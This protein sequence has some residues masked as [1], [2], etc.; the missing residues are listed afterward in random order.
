MEINK[1][2]TPYNYSNGELSRIKYIVI[3]YV[4][5]LGGAE[6]NCKYYA[7]QYVGAS[8]HYFV[9]FSGEIWQSVEDKNIAWH[10]GAKSYIHPECRNSNS[11]GIE[12]C[13]RNKGSQ[14]DT[15]RDWYFEDATV[16]SAIKLTKH[17]MEQY[18][19]REDHVIRHYDVTGKICPNPYVYNH[20]SHTWED[21][22]ES[23]VSAAEVKSGW[24]QEEDGWR[25]YLGNTGDYVKN[26][27]Y[28][29][30]EDWYWF[31][32]AGYMVKDTWKTGSNGKWYYLG[33]TG[34][35][36][37]NQWVIWKEELYRLTADGSMYEGEMRLQTDK[38]GALQ[39]L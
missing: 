25:F 38:N 13:V 21:F 15:S 31:D 4:G 5:A 37:K 11:I 14:S 35:M 27:W 33:D 29:D 26:D 9:G 17:L 18:G 24:M 20:T 23:L 2:I 10:C 36:A 34:K 6:A 28:Q 8:A 22:K 19:I 3:H 32:D 16:A 30:G 1:L 39:T 7:S 12:L